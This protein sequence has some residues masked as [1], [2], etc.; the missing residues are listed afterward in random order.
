MRPG[1]RRYADRETRASKTVGV[2][3]SK[4]DHLSREELIRVLERREREEKRFGLNWERDDIEHERLLNADYVALDPDNSLCVGE[5][6]FHN[7]LIEG[8]NFDALRALLPA[9]AGRVKCV[10][11]DP[12]YNTGQTDFIY[13]DK[14]VGKDD[15]YRHSKWLEMMFQSLSLARDLL[16]DDG[17][18]FV[19]IGE[20]EVHRLGCL[21]D[22][23]MPGRKV[24]SFVWRR[25]SGA[26]DSK[27]Y[28]V[29]Q[30]HEYVLCYANPN[31]SF[32]GDVKSTDA[33][34]NP[35]NDS[36]GAWV[37]SDLTQRK[38]YHQRRNAMYGI[39]NPKNGIWYP[40]DPNSGWAF[41][42]KYKLKSGQKTRSL[43]MEEIIA[44]DK[45]LW[46]Q[47]DEF[48]VYDALS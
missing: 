25:R 42:S 8:P 30:D 20:E 48:V 5:A 22:D 21:L 23:L 24:T 11:I 3:E 16:S 17:V 14:F 10:L 2:M 41:A 33:Y 32:E 18:L 19:H 31:F 45:V 47:N 37:N 15:A 46:P 4:Y 39:Q 7:L 36:R 27:E 13:N 44:A 29:S 34:T 1:A 28:F 38:T 12:P 43:T 26:N 40:A 35:D 6:P 9:F